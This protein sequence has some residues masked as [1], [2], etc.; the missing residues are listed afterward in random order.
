M[1]ISSP[2]LHFSELIAYHEFHVEGFISAGIETAK[3]STGVVIGD[4]T[5]PVD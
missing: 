4:V 2:K 1:Y 3:S 5:S